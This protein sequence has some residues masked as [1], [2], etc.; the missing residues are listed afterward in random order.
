[1]VHEEKYKSRIVLQKQDY[2]CVVRFFV[3]FKFKTVAFP[4]CA[5]ID[6]T[7][8][9]NQF[10]SAMLP[11]DVVRTTQTFIAKTTFLEPLTS[12]YADTGYI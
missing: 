11:Q 1:M 9:T 10:N 6:K 4:H 5:D 8:D 12:H 7:L 2:K 3:F